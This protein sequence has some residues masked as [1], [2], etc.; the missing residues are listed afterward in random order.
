[1]KLAFLSLLFTI[2]FQSGMAQ[3]I[4]FSEHRNDESSDINFEVI[5][6]QGNNI[7]VYK[8]IR[9]KHVMGV[10]NE[11]MKLVS[12]ER[13]KFM[14]DKT[15]NVDFVTYP[16]HFFM[17]YQF[18]RGNV[19]HCMAVRL[20]NDGN[21]V[22]EPF[23]IDT[24]RIGAFADKRIYTVIPSE[25]RSRI[26]VYKMLRRGD[27]LTLVPKVY[28]NRM[29][30]EDSSRHVLSF[31]ERRDVYSELSIT[32]NGSL[33]FT[34]GRKRGNQD[35]IFQLKALIYENESDTLREE[36]IPLGEKFIDEVL[37]KIDNQNRTYILNSLF[38]N[39]LR[40]NIT[41]LF[42]AGLSWEKPDEVATAFNYFPDTLRRKMNN[43]GEY[44][45]AFNNVYLR[46]VILKRDGGFII[47]LEDFYM[48]TTGNNFGRSRYDYLYNY[49]YSNYNDY[50][51]YNPSYYNY[52]RPFYYRN[53]STTH[54]YY[55]NILALSINNK[56][57]VDWNTLLVK[58]QGDVETDN[59]LSFS[60][61]ITGGEIHYL[62]MEAERRNQV[63]INYGLSGS[64]ML[65][66]Y[67]T[68]KGNSSGY[69]FMPRLSRQVS[70]SQVVL[71][72]MYRGYIAFALVDFSR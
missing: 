72:C 23:Q 12:N 61:I 15:F 54:Y 21:P 35:N 29:E 24:S 47:N 22:S 5:G 41:G 10:Y 52:Y 44:S 27:N 58:K 63:V 31:N 38:C 55:D 71:P 11:E 1:M 30:L 28:N 20:G 65:T 25:D 56:F 3:K 66:R 45:A 6:K 64:G 40:G 51:Y 62:F 17:I 9:W 42:T 59:F 48:R 37:I 18:Q 16:D 19:V 57:S 34:R 49:P 32:N 39:E 7:L 60:N 36:E 68:L 43:Q 26:L 69:S 14:P 50:Y 67:G 13:L 70:A 53:L 4:I 33:I 2:L 8:N 46:N